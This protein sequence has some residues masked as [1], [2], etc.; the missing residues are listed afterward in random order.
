MAGSRALPGPAEGIESR[1]SCPICLEL[2][3]QPVSIASC[4]HTFCGDCL[5]PCLQ[6]TSP[7]CPLCRVPFDPKRV[8]R[9]W[10][11]E[12]QLAAHKAPCRGCSKKVSL[13]KMRSHI[14]SC[15]KLQDPSSLCSQF[16]SVES[17]SQPIASDV[18]NRSAFMCPFC[19]ARSLDQQQ[20]LRHCMDQHRSDPH[21]VVCPVCSSMPWGDSAYK[22]A[23]FLQHLLHRHKFS[24]DTFVD[25]SV[26]E[27]AALQAALTLSLAEN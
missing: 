10:S 20:L 6:V 27:E 5:R 8:Q 21:R 7:P 18:P 9:C 19:G 26:D 25:Y 12:K 22:S 24:Y 14:A 16:V 17:T 13:V 15:S 23:N 2:Y 3:H 4:A 11:L 1:F